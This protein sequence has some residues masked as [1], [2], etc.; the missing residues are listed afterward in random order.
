MN[1]VRA[2][3]THLLTQHAEHA[4]FKFYPLFSGKMSEDNAMA[5]GLIEHAILAYELSFNSMFNLTTAECRL[6]YRRQENRG[7]FIVLFKHTQ[8][9]EARACA[10][11]ALEVGKLI[12]AF[13]PLSDPL[14]M[15]LVLDYYAL[16]A[17]QHLWLIQLYQEW[18]NLKKLAQLP[19]MAYSYA[20]CLFYESNGR[21]VCVCDC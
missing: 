3:L 9:L 6:D 19:N 11:T 8:Y 12:L 13:D 5:S 20:L 14:A 4:N 18:E 16:R 10:R 17:K 7:F 15:I 21:F 1:Y 2:D